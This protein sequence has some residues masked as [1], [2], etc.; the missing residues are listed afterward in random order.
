VWAVLCGEGGG[1]GGEVFGVFE[2]GGDGVRG[3]G[4]V[5]WRWADS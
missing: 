1:W 4:G 5:E 3:E 2:G